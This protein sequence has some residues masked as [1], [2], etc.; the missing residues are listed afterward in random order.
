MSDESAKYPKN[1]LDS[2]LSEKGPMPAA[3]IGIRLQAFF[4]DWV[5]IS[6]LA[7]ILV[8]L[9]IPHFFPG[10]IVESNKWLDDFA[11]WITQG[12]FTKNIPMPQ[13]S[14][15]FASTVVFAQLFVFHIFWLY[16]TASDAFFSGYT[17]GKL[18]CRLRT[19]NTVTMKEPL[20]ASS[21]ARGG[22]KAL[23]MFSPLI[24]LATVAVLKFNKRRQMGHDLLCRTAVVDERYLS[25]IDQIR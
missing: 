2:V 22:L 14:E 16:F 23:A 1:V 20:L 6:M 10:A 17:F 13:W 8:R 3:R 5:F 19:V 7:A 11:D 12:G 25:S 9:V 15:S 4:F 18:I 21:I 24:L